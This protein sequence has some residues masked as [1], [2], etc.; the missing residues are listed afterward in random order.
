MATF[1]LQPLADLARQMGYTPPDRRRENIERA[2][3]LYW[4]LEPD[5]PYPLA[6]IVF[7]ITRHRVDEDSELTMLVGQAVRDDLPALVEQVSETLAD[8]PDRYD[9]PPLDLGAACA[10]LGVTP[11]TLARYRKQGLFA[12]RLLYPSKPRPRMK[13]AFLL[14]SIERFEAAKRDQ[15]DHAKQFDRMADDDR[16]RIVLRARRI[17]GRT[18]ASPFRVAQHLA[19][20]TGRSV[21]AIRKLLVD[22]DQ[23]DPRFAIFPKHNGPL[24]AND[25]HAIADAYAAG[26]SVAALAERYGKTR[27]A[28]YRAINH[29]RAR[30]LRQRDLRHVE[31]PTFKLPNAESVILETE[32]TGDPFDD[33][34]TE[35]AMFVRYN[36]CK[37]LAMRTRDTLDRYRPR[38]GKLDRAET[39]A[40]YADQLE[41]QLHDAY[42]PEVIATAKRHLA[43]R[44][45]PGGPSLDALVDAGERVLHESI[46]AFD[47]GR[48]TR[49]E[50]F[51]RYAL[52]R[53][54]AR[55]GQ[56]DG[57]RPRDDS[58]EATGDAKPSVDPLMRVLSVLEARERAVV[59]QHLGLTDGNESAGPPRTLAQIGA[60]LG[61]SAER[62]RQIEHRAMKKL[63]A[64]AAVA[65]VSL[66]ELLP[67]LN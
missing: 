65:G 40:R 33:A 52:M 48:G 37:Y 12:R 62:A 10:R 54:F 14:P 15:L 47:A 2:E 23:R 7:R 13:L 67:G 32:L 22:H 17:A 11:R 16:H 30:V 8:P 24:S 44:A 61:V 53:H 28:I 9:P 49:F 64:E 18:N 38:A 41:Q 31:S 34:E 19:R 42:Q 35:Q 5:T 20:R 1:R 46:R 21:E 51:V 3:S 58:T 60:A 50:P 39:L 56:R 36:F 26:E 45:A 27:D 6:Y 55:D 43:A 4:Q 57:A 25:Q 66:D 59:V 63:R 29:Q